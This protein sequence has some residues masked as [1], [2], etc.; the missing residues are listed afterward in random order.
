METET[1]TF[2][3]SNWIEIKGQ[4]I[5]LDKI[6]TFF[7]RDNHLIFLETLFCDVSYSNQFDNE[8]RIDFETH[9]E[10][11]VEY[12]RLKKILIGE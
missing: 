3:Q 1:T 10:A 7:A 8:L 11:Q 5:N 2:K 12:D 4:M 9:E 6:S